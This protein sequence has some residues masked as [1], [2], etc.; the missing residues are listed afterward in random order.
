MK[1]IS[2]HRYIGNTPSNNLDFH[3]WLAGNLTDDPRRFLAAGCH[4]EMFLSVVQL[5][6]HVRLSAVM[7]SFI[8]S[9]VVSICI[10]LIWCVQASPMSQQVKNAPAVQETQVRFLGQEGL[11]GKQVLRRRCL[12][13]GGPE[14]GAVLGNLT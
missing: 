2:L 10:K 8:Y 7:N 4:D 12:S 3:L 6:S 13:T 11:L 14:Q 5:L 9:S 1:Y